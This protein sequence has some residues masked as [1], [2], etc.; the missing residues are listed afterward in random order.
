MLE[1]EES[2]FREETRAGF[3]ISEMMKRTWA[4]EMKVLTEVAA[5]CKKYHLQWYA[6]YGTLLGAVRHQG[7]VPWDDDIDIMMKRED[8]VKLFEVLPQE[9]P[10]TYGINSS[11]NS[12]RHK[13]PLGSVANSKGV[14]RDDVRTKN[15]YGCP[16][17]VGIDIYPLDFLPKDRELE[18]TQL[19]LYSAVYDVAKRYDELE[20]TGEL[21][22]Y[23]PQI[24][25]LCGV[26]FDR[27]EDLR[28][29]FWML[30]ERLAGLFGEEESDRL[31][32]IYSLVC[33][34]R[35]RVFKREWFEDS[36]KMPFENIEINVPRGYHEV[37]T[38]KYGDYSVI[39]YGGAHEYPF[40]K[41]QEPYL[42]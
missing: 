13:Q 11:Y 17:V 10:T 20:R 24:E 14:Y 23:I 1:F 40:Y 33:G 3:T 38:K 15:F 25:E 30:A 18:E 22:L 29:Q 39:R 37:L 2:Y 21:H 28:H 4:A 7:F 41:K 12:K 26:Q 36:I 32:I 35:E 8:Y 5:V 16:Y 34:H 19:L 6:A 31:A 42:K 27:Q 9:L